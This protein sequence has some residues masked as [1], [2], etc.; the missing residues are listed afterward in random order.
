MGEMEQVLGEE[1]FEHLDEHADV[2][3]T[4]ILDHFDEDEEIDQ[5]RF[6]DVLVENA[7]E[8][9]AQVHRNQNG[10]RKR[11]ERSFLSFLSCN[12][13]S[14]DMDSDDEVQV[15]GTSDE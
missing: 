9:C 4:A 8:I 14:A 15:V 5:D 13:C 6:H 12:G 2:N 1:V 11:A 10:W 7:Q 3:C